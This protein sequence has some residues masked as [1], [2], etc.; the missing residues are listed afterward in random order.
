MQR[1]EREQR[2]CREWL[3]AEQDGHDEL[4]ELTFA[5]LVA[6]LPPIEASPAFV[7][8]VVQ[9]AWR[10]HLRRR[11]VSRLARVAAVLVMAGV[12]AATVYVLG[13]ILVN[14]LAQGTV[15]LSEALLWLLTSAGD[16]VRW[17][18]VAARVSAAVSESLVT[19]RTAAAI[20]LIEMLGASAIYALQRVLRDDHDS[21]QVHI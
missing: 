21:Q 11:A 10:A 2:N 18:S 17:W 4:A 5:R 8:T 15:L 16:G 1:D 9:R 20:V 19:P 13:G 3:A 6:E 12:T 14:T 7:D